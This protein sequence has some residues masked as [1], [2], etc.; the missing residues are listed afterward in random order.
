MP[1]ITDLLKLEKD[2]LVFGDPVYHLIQCCLNGNLNQVKSSQML[3][4]FCYEN[5]YSVVRLG[6]WLAGP[7]LGPTIFLPTNIEFDDSA[8]NAIVAQQRAN[9]R[10]CEVERFGKPIER[11]SDVSYLTFP[12]CDVLTSHINILENLAYGFKS[13]LEIKRLDKM[14]SRKG[15][16]MYNRLL[17]TELEYA[18]RNLF[19]TLGDLRNFMEGWLESISTVYSPD[20]RIANTIGLVMSKGIGVSM[21]ARNVA[22]EL[23]KLYASYGWKSDLNAHDVYPLIHPEEG[24][25]ACFGV[26]QAGQL[27]MHDADGAFKINANRYHWK[28]DPF[29]AWDQK[30]NELPSTCNA[31][32]QRRHCSLLFNYIFYESEEHIDKKRHELVES[33]DIVLGGYQNFLDSNQVIIV[34]G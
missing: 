1:E 15:S 14:E 32:R 30:P 27:V 2:R 10:G 12:E 19:K 33:L 17:S 6:K 22:L 18:H 29:A 31:C 9:F 16:P 20:N 7:D 34:A 25:A 5:P 8:Y 13:A 21:S 24:G 23:R 4:P 11:N 28:S 3:D 26:E